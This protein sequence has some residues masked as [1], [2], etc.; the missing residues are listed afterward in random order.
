MLDRE[1][2]LLKVSPAPAANDASVRKHKTFAKLFDTEVPESIAGSECK[3]R[4]QMKE[5]WPEGLDNAQ[6]VS[7]QT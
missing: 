3:D 2:K 1:P 7:T 4:D 6:E 5:S